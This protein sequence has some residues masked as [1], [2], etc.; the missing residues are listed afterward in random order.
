[1]NAFLIPRTGG[2]L[3]SNREA[4][5]QMLPNAQLIFS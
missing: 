5:S 1:M 2:L 4:F 3:L